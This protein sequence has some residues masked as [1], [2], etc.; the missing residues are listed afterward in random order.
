MEFNDYQKIARSTDQFQNKN[1]SLSRS[2]LKIQEDVLL[3]SN[4]YQKHGGKELDNK[5]HLSYIM[6]KLGDVL[7]YASNIASCHDITLEDV[8]D[9]NIKKSELRWGAK[10]SNKSD[11][12]NGYS[13]TE[14]LPKLS[15]FRINEIGTQ[16]EILTEDKYGNWFRIG[17][18]ITDNNH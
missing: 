2:I 17:D 18:R 13:E 16:I 7:W 15:A 5:D 11:F 12:D 6:S 1:R 3:L 8:V 4:Y 10:I 9:F 14:I